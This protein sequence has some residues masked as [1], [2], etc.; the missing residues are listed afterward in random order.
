[1]L[2]EAL[3]IPPLQS[4]QL[5]EQLS[6]LSTCLCPASQSWCSKGLPFTEYFPQ[7]IYTHNVNHCPMSVC[8][9]H[10]VEE[11]LGA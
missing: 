4:S 2:A 3:H 10:F 7:V 8:H 5:S 1:M 6:H 11:E 9:L